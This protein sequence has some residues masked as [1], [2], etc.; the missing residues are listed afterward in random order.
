MKRKDM[1]IVL[2]GQR[3]KNLS[4]IRV[5]VHGSMDRIKLLGT[6]RVKLLCEDP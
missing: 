2:I 1:R 6:N 4:M 5:K 3:A